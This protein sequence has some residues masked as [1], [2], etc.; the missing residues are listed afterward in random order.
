VVYIVPVLQPHDPANRVNF[1]TES[2][3]LFMMVKVTLNLSFFS[4]TAWFQLHK[5]VNSQTSR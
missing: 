1:V 4:N 3:S 5:E 2:F